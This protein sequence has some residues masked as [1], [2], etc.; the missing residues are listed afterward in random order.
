[1]ADLGF[2][3]DA[4]G[5]PRGHHCLRI[6]DPG[7]IDIIEQPLVFAAGVADFRQIGADVTREVCTSRWPHHVASDAGSTPRA[8]RNQFLT[9]RRISRNGAGYFARRGWNGR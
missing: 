5:T 2:V 1:M 8:I 3:E 6:I 4:M 9:D 7:V